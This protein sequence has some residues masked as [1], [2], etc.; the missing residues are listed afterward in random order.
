[1]TVLERKAASGISTNKVGR[2]VGVALVAG[3]LGVVGALGVSNLTEGA[4][5]PAQI[6]QIRAGG[7]VDHQHGLWLARVEAT[8]NAEQVARFEGPFMAKVAQIQ[9]Q[10]A[11]DMAEHFANQNSARAAAIAEQR[12]QDMAE[13][14]YGSGR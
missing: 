14:K 4:L 13:F 11:A 1:M 8:R 5:S 7:Q 3:T 6:E 10:R 2:Y 9:E 12:G